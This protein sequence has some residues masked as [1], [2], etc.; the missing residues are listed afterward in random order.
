VRASQATLSHERLDYRQVVEAVM[1]IV[2]SNAYSLNTKGSTTTREIF[3]VSNKGLP[4]G[5]SFS[6]MLV[7]IFYA[8]IDRTFLKIDSS[9]TVLI[10]LVDDMLCFSTKRDEVDR[11][12]YLLVDEAVYFGEI[13]EK[14]LN[15]GTA[16]DSVDWAG[17]T[18]FPDPLK[19][20]ISVRQP[21]GSLESGETCAK[22]DSLV[23]FLYRSVAQHCLPLLF[24]TEINSMNGIRANAHSAG[25]VCGRRIKQWLRNN[26]LS[27]EK[28]F[29]EF[30][31]RLKKFPKKIDKKFQKIF[32]SSL[33]HSLS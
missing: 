12:L 1:K 16:P 29:S 15:V 17:F 10:R 20:R 9:C 33:L 3:R 28:D 6:V 18:M 27:S 26:Q 4:Q 13:N 2:R 21:L 8:Y 14:K 25:I 32:R 7:A 30:A 19:K 11:L 5:S 22:R 24:S 31:S 23:S